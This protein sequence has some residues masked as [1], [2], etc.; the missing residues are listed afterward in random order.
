MEKGS[1][2]YDPKRDGHALDKRRHTD[3][4]AARRMKQA[5]GRFQ[6]YAV[7][8][9]MEGTM[10]TQTMATG[11]DNRTSG[12]SPQWRARL[13]ATHVARIEAVKRSLGKVS[14]T[15]VLIE[16]LDAYE[17]GASQPAGWDLLC[18]MQ[19]RLGLPTPKA[20]IE[21]FIEL[22]EVNDKRV[23]RI[24]ELERNNKEL[25]AIN[26]RLH[27]SAATQEREYDA[28]HTAYREVMDQ[29]NALGENLNQVLSAPRV[30][31]SNPNAEGILFDFVS[32]FT[33]ATM[34]ADAGGEMRVTLPDTTSFFGIWHRAVQ[35][36]GIGRKET[37]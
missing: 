8:A 10:G 4:K 32:A 7:L 23:A 25:E 36:L 37:A 5:G 2:I 13:N 12:A 21:R 3:P 35:C 19:G 24:V 11:T 14:N 6:Q 1:G 17:R 20:T 27:A 15:D 33:G 34:T 9:A 31:P 30:I 22:Y 18:A 28:L 26:D 16:L 29:R